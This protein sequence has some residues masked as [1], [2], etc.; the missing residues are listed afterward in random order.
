MTISPEPSDAEV[1]ARTRAGERAAFA[2][3]VRRY[4]DVAQ[5]TAAVLGAGADVDDVVQEAFVKAYGALGGFRDGAEF[6]PWLLR[7][8]AN[9]TRNA[10]R[11]VR[12]RA[13]RERSAYVAAGGDLLPPLSAVAD[14]ERHAQDADALEALRSQVMTLPESQ[15]LV[16]A[17]RY[18]L[19]LD[20]AETAAVLGVARGTVKSRAHR[21]LRHL[22]GRLDAGPSGPL[23]PDEEVR[24][25]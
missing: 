14:P 3:L 19:D 4:A 16:I 23:E 15:R 17:C 24:R 10:Q 7:I 8:V 21:A 12:R 25:A 20:E 2:I 9:E 6:R 13:A 5:R 18:L 22:R 11:S 1:V